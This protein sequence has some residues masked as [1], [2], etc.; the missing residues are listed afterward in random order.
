MVAYTDLVVSHNQK[1]IVQELE[2]IGM[3]S[4]RSYQS[5]PHAG[6]S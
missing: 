1:S 4:P 3:A 6:A 5:F 2:E